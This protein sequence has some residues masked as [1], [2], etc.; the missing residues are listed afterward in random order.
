[1]RRR[2]AFLAAVG[3]VGSGALAGCGGV[4]D[5]GERLA[6]VDGAVGLPGVDGQH[7]GRVD[8]HDR[9]AAPTT[10][11]STTTENP[12]V[13]P[14]RLYGRWLV[15]R[16]RGDRDRL[17]V[18]DARTGAVSWRERFEERIP[19]RFV[20]L[21]DAVCARSAPRRLTCYELA[22]GEVRWTCDVQYPLYATPVVL[23]GRLVL[24]DEDRLLAVDVADG[25]TVWR[26]DAS[27]GFGLPMTATDDRVLA[28]TTT[29]VVRAVDANDSGTAWRRDLDGRV[30]R[31]PTVDGERAFVPVAGRGVVA[32][33]L[34]DGA[35]AWERG[36]GSPDDASGPDDD[37]DAVLP[38]T[39][40]VVHRD[41]LYVGTDRGV[42]RVSVDGSRREIVHE[43]EVPV[44]NRLVVAGDTLYGWVQTLGAF[45]LSL[46]AGDRVWA[47]DDVGVDLVPSREH[48]FGRAGLRTLEAY[49]DDE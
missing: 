45:A 10:A 15:T 38:E 44:G 9:V 35:V 42:E 2:R 37:A 32:L 27:D 13:W 46:P 14:P 19:G 5:G 16:E 36:L 22:T 48:L 4:L 43:T 25:E 49:R 11:W 34:A 40:P 30:G 1:M 6:S 3:A 21:D 23:G 8:E 20:V 7:S 41:W 29:G 24:A 39:A 12:P 47:T 17:V 31:P 33:S 28:S 26:V 18:R